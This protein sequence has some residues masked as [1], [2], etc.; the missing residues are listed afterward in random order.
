MN[1]KV[2]FITTAAIIAAMYAVLTL[3]FSFSSY[4][5]IQFR[6]SEA[7]TVLPFFTPAAIPGLFIGCI[8]GNLNSIFGPIDVVCGSVATLLA[9]CLTRIMPNKF[10]APL[11]PIVVNA[12]V[13]GIE[14]HYSAL[15]L[16]M[17]DV[18]QYGV[19]PSMLMVAAGEAAVCYGLGFPLMLALNKVKS[20]IF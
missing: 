12:V 8:L 10:L 13:V 14:I 7:L 11:P 3:A 20:K 2:K 4:G 17:P 19:V 15:A 9:A 5:L 6:V 16:H 1:K 18:A